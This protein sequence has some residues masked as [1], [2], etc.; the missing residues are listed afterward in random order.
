MVARIARAGRTK[1]RGEVRPT[2]GFRTQ[3]R[4]G[5]MHS[6]ITSGASAEQAGATAR[7]TI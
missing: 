1:S 6:E 4:V 3:N 5:V 2:R 7:A